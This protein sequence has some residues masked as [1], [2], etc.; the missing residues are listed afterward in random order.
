MVDLNSHDVELDALID[1][2]HAE[3]WS[4]HTRPI[5][6]LFGWER[7]AEEVSNYRLTIDDFTNDLTARDG[8]E[9]LLGW[10]SPLLAEELE[11]VQTS[12]TTTT[13]PAHRRTVARR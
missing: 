4:Q 12:R 7:L 13:E 9:L 1:R 10:A 2:L 6:L 8:L 3:G 11:G 5:E